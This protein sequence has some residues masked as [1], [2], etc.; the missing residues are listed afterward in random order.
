MNNYIL[1]P[2]FESIVARPN[3]DHESTVIV[4]FPFQVQWVKRERR[5]PGLAISNVASD[6]L[7]LVNRPG[8]AGGSNS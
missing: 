4:K 5:K 3:E 7:K 8:F 1:A 6:W 2:K